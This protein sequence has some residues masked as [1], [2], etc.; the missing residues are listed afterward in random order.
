MNEVQKEILVEKGLQHLKTF[1]RYISYH[2]VGIKNAKRD[3]EKGNLKIPVEQLLKE[4]IDSFD[5]QIKRI[6]LVLS[7]FEG[8]GKLEKHN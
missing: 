1:D 6:D 4:I 3:F 2:T 5:E 7:I 8:L